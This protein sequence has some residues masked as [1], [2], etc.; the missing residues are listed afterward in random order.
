MIIRTPPKLTN[1]DSVLKYIE[2]DLWSW[3]RD[4]SIGI[5]KID[6]RQN[7]QSFI[8]E[9]LK[10]PAGMEVSIPNAFKR[11][12]PGV[13]PSARI[14]TRQIGDAHIIDGDKKWTENEVFLKNPSVND[15][16]I[17]VIFFK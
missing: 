14:I 7:F 13:I 8:V 12:Y 2:V 5:L 16:T 1:R 17:S 11:S 4:L 3:L 10:I 15:S 6:F 9:N